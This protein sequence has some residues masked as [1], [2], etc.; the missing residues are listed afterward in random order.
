MFSALILVA[1]HCVVV[2]VSWCVVSLKLYSE[3]EQASRAAAA[4][5][6]AAASATNS[7]QQPLQDVLEPDGS[8]SSSSSD[9]DAARWEAIQRMKAAGVLYKTRQEEAAAHGQGLHPAT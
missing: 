8:G 5:L 7:L 9:V 3:S 2:T 6:A 1:W 4:T